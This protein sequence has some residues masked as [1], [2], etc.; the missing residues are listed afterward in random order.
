MEKKLHRLETF[1]ARG[2]D[3]KVY[4]VHGYEHL[5]R[6]EAVP[7]TQAQWE[8][9]GL[10]EYRLADGRHVSVDRSGAMTLRDS[11]VRLERAGAG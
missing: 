5:A 6:L 2:S 7:E 9:T 1:N 8:P 10:A 4:A 11:G 3:G